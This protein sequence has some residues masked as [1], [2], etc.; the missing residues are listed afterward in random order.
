MPF[1]IRGLTGS[2]GLTGHRLLRLDKPDRSLCQA[3]TPADDPSGLG[4]S[5]LVAEESVNDTVAILTT[6]QIVADHFDLFVAGRTPHLGQ[7]G[8]AT[9]TDALRHD[10]ITSAERSTCV[11]GERNR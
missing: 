5:R 3:R 2:N 9:I 8:S 1:G 10:G 4:C 6:G 11:H 7:D